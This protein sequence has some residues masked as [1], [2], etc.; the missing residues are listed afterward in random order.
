MQSKQYH[1][2]AVYLPGRLQEKLKWIEDFPMTFLEAPPGYGKTT[3]LKCFFEQERFASVPVHWLTILG[4]SE[5][6]SWLAFA[7][8]IGR[9]D[10]ACGEELQRL[11]SLSM[12]NL[13]Q[14]ESILRRIICPEETY[15]VLDNINKAKF[16]ETPHFIEIISGHGGKKLHI[17]AVTTQVTRQPYAMAGGNRNIYY[18]TGNEFTFTSEDTAA[19]LKQ[20][21]I[22]L[23]KEQIRSVC[24][25][26]DGWIFAIYLQ[27]LAFIQTG[28]FANGDMGVLIENSLWR[29]MD[30]KA[31]RC[32]I[33]LSVVPEFTIEQ[34]L[35]LTGCTREE[36]EENLLGNGFLS[37]NRQK[38]LYHFH[39]IFSE[40]LRQRFKELPQEEKRRIWLRAGLWA[41]KSGERIHAL[42]F[43]YA[44]GE[45]EKIFVM[46]AASYDLA[47]IVD[48]SSKHIV[49]DMLNEAPLELKVR[50][51]RAMISIAL[52]LFVL[53]MNE[54]LSRRASEIKEIIE[55]SAL[56][57]KEKNSLFGEMELLLSCLEYNRIKAMNRRHRRALK[58]LE[59]PAKS[60]NIKST[61]T[62]GSPS[63]LYMF[64]R[65]SGKL[66]EELEDMDQCM[67]IYYRLTGGHGRGAEHMMRAEALFM[68]GELES[69]EILCHKVLSVA[70]D[71]CQSSIIQCALFHLARIA[72]MRGE[73]TRLSTIVGLMEEHGRQNTEDL[74]RF[75]LD[76]S[77]SFLGL[78][79]G[80]R[81]WISPW[82]ETGDFGKRLAIMTVPFAH[83]IHGIALLK[84]KDFPRMLGVGEVYLNAA[85]IF[86]NLLPQVYILIYMSLASEGMGLGD[87][88]EKLLKQALEIAIPDRIYMPFAENGEALEGILRRV[89]KNV[90]SSRRFSDSVANLCGEGKP[91]SARIRA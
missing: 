54:E 73:E 49:L 22:S 2:R 83:I 64:W 38:N 66:Q 75:T 12:D 65:E 18:L 48:D 23:N 76:L 37:F 33:I 68:S 59:G 20:V 39:A 47:D 62:L 51:P 16:F 78:H 72:L 57:Q 56:T 71:H 46:A 19:Y 30:D 41:E 55:E 32:C 28:S 67:P 42:Q 82:L 61:W 34:A 15:I 60:I 9:V 6:A 89:E 1:I 26:T 44:A 86:P 43:Y 52:T 27:M 31:Q 7:D 69:A 91:F 74:C 80:R 5:Q 77:K 58:L 14:V 13:L 81:D 88:A 8:I 40:F 85:S 53:G 90:E 25:S 4:E 84:Q 70:G 35:Y 36:A 87:Q 10:P 29:H 21:G 17:V 63:V 11:G 50:Y 3:A 45:L 79:I 24:E